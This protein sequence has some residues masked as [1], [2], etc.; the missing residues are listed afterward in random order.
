VIP[1]PRSGRFS[2]MRAM[3]PITSYVI[4]LSVSIRNQSTDYTDLEFEI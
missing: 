2:V 4:V 1:L 3:R